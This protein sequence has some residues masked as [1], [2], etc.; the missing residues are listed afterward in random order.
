MFYQIFLGG[1]DLIILKSRT[2]QKRKTHLSQL[3]V[4]FNGMKSNAAFILL[5][6]HF[7]AGQPADWAQFSR[8]SLALGHK[9]SVK[10]RVSGPGSMNAWRS[11]TIIRRVNTNFLQV[12]KQINVLN[13]V[14]FF[15]CINLI[16]VDIFL[17]LLFYF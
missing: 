10:S 6:H 3:M 8:E 16:T 9:L 15:S 5:V 1:I 14:S 12:N 2:G 13:K 11:G 17:V 4:K 7:P